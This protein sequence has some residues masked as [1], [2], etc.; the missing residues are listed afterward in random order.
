MYTQE[1]KR[2]AIELYIKTNQ[3]IK[4]VISTLGY[5][6]PNMLRNWYKGY[7]RGEEP[8]QKRKSKYSEDYKESVID[9]YFE[10]GENITLTAK[11]TGIPR[12]T[13]IDWL[14]ERDISS[15][16]DCIS[17]TNVVKY[18]D[19]HKL[20]AVTEAVCGTEPVFRICA[21]YGISGTTLDNWRNQLMGNDSSYDMLKE[22]KES[23]LKRHRP[24]DE[25]EIDELRLEY[26]KLRQEAEEREA[27]LHKVSLERDVLKVTL[28][29]LKK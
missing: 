26:E 18:S 14:Q 5:P 25:L 13:L 10:N 19:E 12:S 21:K 1:Q 27:L 6:S 2:K 4:A 22:K 3:S 24:S 9:K 23:V 16:P 17:G 29:I 7:L 15:K 8:Q 20:M 28:Q 11:Q